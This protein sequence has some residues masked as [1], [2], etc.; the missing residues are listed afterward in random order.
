MPPISLY[1]H[2]P[3][4]VRKCPYCDFNSYAAKEALPQAQYIDAVQQDL[5]QYESIL[6]T[7][8]IQSIFIGGGTPSLFHADA[9]AT[10]LQF[11]SQ[12]FTCVNE[13]E[14]TLEAN[15]G[16]MEQGRFDGFLQ[17]GVNRLSIGIQ[18]FCDTQLKTLGRIHNSDEAKKAI[19]SARLA[20]FTNFNLDLMFGLPN[21]SIAEGLNDLQTALAFDPT[22]LS[23][24]QLTLEPNT[25]F[26]KYPPTLPQH[27]DI[28]DMQLAGQA[29][30]KAHHYHQYEIS[31]Y[32]KQNKPCKHNL[33]YWQ[34]GDYIGIGAG[35]HGKISHGNRIERY[36]NYRRPQDYLDPDRPFVG[37]RHD[38]APKELALEFMM[39]ALRQSAPIPKRVFTQRT[40]LPINKIQ[41]ALLEAEK[42]G[43]IKQNTNQFQVTNHGQQYLNEA[44]ILFCN[45]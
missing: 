5:L 42:K 14:V 30:L 22:H 21:Q 33:N 6:A 45:D 26:H 12:H 16:T 31:A 27:D 17:A 25:V 8:A 34:F 23:W 36:W 40:G 19:E 13:M 38:I 35:A 9:I 37:N 24:Y 28:A 3:W 10:L 11:I 18:S 29:L 4:C 32:C 44:L 1:I 2:I 7:R 43:F 41:A 20:G 15:P 39:N